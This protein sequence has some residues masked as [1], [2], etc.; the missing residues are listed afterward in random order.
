[1]PTHEPVHHLPA[2]SPWRPAEGVRSPRPGIID[3]CVL[4]L[5]CW[6]LTLGL[7]EQRVILNAMPSLLIN[8]NCVSFNKQELDGGVYSLHV[9]K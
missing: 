3:L 4:P 8:K 5:G 9:D 2:C 6:E 7:E 1:M